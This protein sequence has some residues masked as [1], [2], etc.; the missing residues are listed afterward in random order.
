MT[1]RKN[2]RKDK[3]YSKKKPRKATYFETKAN[4]DSASKTAESLADVSNWVGLI[5]SEL[6]EM[7]A[8][9][10][11][12]PY[13]YC[14]TMIFWMMALAGE[15]DSS[16]RNIVGDANG[17]L[18]PYGLKAPSRSTFLRRSQELA[19]SLVGTRRE[20]VFAV[21]VSPNTIARERRVGVDSTGLN[22]SCTTLWRLNKWGTG[23]KHRGWL[24]LHAMADLDTEEIIAWA[25]TDDR[26]GDS[27]LFDVLYKHAIATGHRLSAVYA[28]N[29]YDSIKHWKLLKEDNVK[30]VTRFKSTTSGKS[31][32]CVERGNMAKLWIRCEGENWAELTGYGFRWKI[33]CTFSDLK[34][35]VSEFVAARKKKGWIREIFQK[36][37]FFNIHKQIRAD[38][39]GTT[40][41]GVKVA[42][43]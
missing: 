10:K 8:G 40:G 38:I 35:M 6:N 43:C 11:G 37:V 21:F 7:N 2:R 25:I 41:N 23:P 42:V 13:E 31:R 33:E 18:K 29:A 20:G 15:N 19:N 17:R 26:V 1:N 12:R 39:M 30:F 4:N 3:K 34:R 16:I 28:D 27:K 5:T 32:G 14:D 22:L 9:K 36:I 24:K